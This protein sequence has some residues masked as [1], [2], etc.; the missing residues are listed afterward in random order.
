MFMHLAWEVNV[1]LVI[2]DAQNGWE[3]LFIQGDWKVLAA[4]MYA[5]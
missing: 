1:V 5:W 4:F 2:C 3:K